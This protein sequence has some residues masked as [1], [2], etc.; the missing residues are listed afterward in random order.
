MQENADSSI[1]PAIWK[2][3]PLPAGKHAIDKMDFEDTSGSR[4]VLSVNKAILVA[5]GHRQGGGIDYDDV[6]APWPNRAD[7][8]IWLLLLIWAFWYIRLDRKSLF[9]WRHWKK[10]CYVTQPKALRSLLPKHVTECKEL[11]MELHQANL[12]PYAT[13]SAFSF[14]YTTNYRFDYTAWLSPAARVY[15]IPAD[16]LVSSACTN[17][18]IIA[19]D[20]VYNAGGHTSCLVDSFLLSGVMVPA[21]LN[22]CAVSIMF[23]LADFFLLVVTCFCCAQLDIAVGC[24]LAAT[25]TVVL[26]A[27]PAERTMLLPYELLTTTETQR[28][29]RTSLSS[30]SPVRESSPGEA[31]LRQNGVMGYGTEKTH[32]KLVGNLKEESLVS[33]LNTY[34][35]E[36][37]KDYSRMTSEAL[38]TIKLLVAAEDLEKRRRRGVPL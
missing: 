38:V 11:C 14:T 16:R 26:L 22:V 13:M 33:N 4:E 31:R 23:L 29:T 24:L 35:V 6:F 8:C 28:H 3:V 18:M 12:E 9:S 32:C 27:M 1:Q 30:F 37:L 34:E 2:L 15:I 20:A 5:T 36:I 17:L 25:I 19:A 7:N 21:V 10:K